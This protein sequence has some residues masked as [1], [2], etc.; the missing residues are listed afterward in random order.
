MKKFDDALESF[1]DADGIIIDLRGNAGG[2]D[3]MALGM[4]GWLA[5][6]E[7]MA[8]RIRMRDN[9]IEMIV[10]PRA[11]IY[12]RSGRCSYRRSHGVI[13]RIRGCHTAGD[14]TGLRHRH[15]DKG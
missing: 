14:G 1:M 10:R 2:K 7:W 3:T 11:Q 6:E 15:A 12:G 9:E 8:G 5:S 13:R 4:M